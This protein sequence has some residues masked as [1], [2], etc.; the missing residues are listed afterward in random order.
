MATVKQATNRLQ[1]EI[2]HLR[3]VV[4]AVVVTAIVGFFILGNTSLGEGRSV[5]YPVVLV[6]AGAATANNV[7]RLH[8][9]RESG[10]PSVDDRLVIAQIYLSP[11]VGATF[12]VLLYGLFMAGVLEGDFF[13]GFACASDAY[14]GFGDFADCSPET[15]ADAAKAMVWGFVA[16]YSER[17]VPNI[18]DRMTSSVTPDS[19]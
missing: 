2:K 5:V 3:I 10:M 7:R 8:R 9:V 14:E 13:P 15:N 6:A 17:F 12:A 18:L 19:A 11:V 16:G 1:V 4:I